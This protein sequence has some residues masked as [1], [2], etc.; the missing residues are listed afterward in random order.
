MQEKRC[1]SKQ[2]DIVIIRNTTNGQRY[3]LNSYIYHEKPRRSEEKYQIDIGNDF[4]ILPNKQRDREMAQRTF[5]VTIGT[6]FI[7]GDTVYTVVK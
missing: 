4:V 7:V 1:T 5:E 6:K 2:K 3:L